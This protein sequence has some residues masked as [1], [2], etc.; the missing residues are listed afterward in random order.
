MTRKS[1]TADTENYGTGN[2]SRYEQKDKKNTHTKNTY[3]NTHTNTEVSR[4]ACGTKA[5][6]GYQVPDLPIYVHVVHE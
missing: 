2:H 1:W 3:K 5:D 4:K 6:Q